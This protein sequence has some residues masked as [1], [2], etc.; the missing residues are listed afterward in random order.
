[1]A[2][3]SVA[4]LEAFSGN[5]ETD[6]TTLK[7]ALC[8][9]AESVVVDHLGY[10]PISATR[11]F[12]TVGVGLDFL[13]LP[14]PAVTSITSITEDGVTLAATAYSL[15]AHGLKYWVERSDGLAFAR[16]AKIVITYVAGY[17]A[18][19]D[20]I[21]HAAKRI[22]ALMLEESHGNIG[23]SSKSFADLS[24][25]FINYTN[26]SKYLAPLAPYVAESI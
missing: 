2:L 10:D 22:A 26:Y 14:I 6:N 19:P 12:R 23:V 1:M 7:T 24:K 16:D 15:V 13:I 4:E 9:S 17:S 3:I 5:L 8:A 18:A 20:I 21:K 25:T 11:S